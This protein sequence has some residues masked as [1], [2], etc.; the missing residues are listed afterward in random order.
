VYT[1]SL[2]RL[3]PALPLQSGMIA[4]GLRDPSAGT[5]VI[6]CVQ[7]WPN[8]LDT[9]A[10]L[11]AWR[12]A[13]ER[14]AVLRTRFA[15]RADG[16]LEQ[17]AGSAEDVPVRVDGSVTD[18]DAFLAAD[19]RAGVDPVSGPPLRVVA[20][21]GNVVVATFHHA[22]LDGRSLAML[23]GEVDD[24]Y[25]ARLAGGAATF[26]PRPDFADY[27]RWYDARIAPDHP[28]QLADRRFWAAELAGAP[29]PGPLPLE[30]AGPDTPVMAT[31]A[32]DLSAA[33]TEAVNA[34]A[35]GVGITVNTVVLAAWAW[36][37]PRTR[38]ATRRC[39]A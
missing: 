26:P 15:W 21:P 27:A 1:E 19:R 12:A 37:W 23:L 32:L 34:L 7:H 39:S 38:A 25:A 22:I 5:D 28:G 14:H 6:Q 18:L 20:L 10:Y 13:V 16:E 24:D 29:E 8:G 3:A 11:S 33:E 35:A 30:H 9:D 31:A 2:A 17:W 36:S 4:A